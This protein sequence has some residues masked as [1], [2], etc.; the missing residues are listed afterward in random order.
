MSQPTYYGGPNHGKPDLRP[1]VYVV[2]L[3]YGHG[4]GRKPEIFGASFDLE[5][6][7]KRALKEA[8]ELRLWESTTHM[9]ADKGT[10]KWAGDDGEEMWIEALALEGNTLDMI[11]AAI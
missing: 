10:R 9:D 3:Q 5:V 6:T 4:E 7:L 11:A 1:R 2:V 8:D